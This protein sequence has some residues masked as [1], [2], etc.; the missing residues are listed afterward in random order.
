MKKYSR[1]V[2][3]VFL[4]IVWLISSPNVLAEDYTFGRAWQHVQ[5]VSDAIASEQANVERSELLQ[6]A[7]KSLNYPQVELSGSYTRLD[8]EVKADALD[9]NPLSGLQDNPIGQDI[10][11]ALGGQTAFTTDITNQSFGRLALTALWP[12]YTGGR[13]TAAQDI[14]K[15]Q[16]EIATQLFDIQRHTVFEELVKIYFGVVLSQQNLETHKQAELGFQQHLENAKKLESQGQI[17]KVERLS[18]AV[19]HDRARI[20]TLKAQKALEIA[21]VSLRQLLHASVDVYPTDQL[22]T[23][24]SIPED[25]IFISSSLDSS[26]LLKSLEARDR[27]LQAI[28]KSNRGRYHPEVSLYADYALYNDDSIVSDLLP[29]WSVGIG[30]TVPLV[31]RFNR[32]KNIGATLKAQE[33]VARLSD[34]TRRALTV[35]TQVAYKKAQ[36]ALQEFEGR[37]S[38]LELSKENLFMRQKAFSEGLSTS[39]QLIDSEVFVSVARTE[40]SA[41]AYQYI[42]SLSQLLTLSGEVGSFGQYQN[43]ARQEKSFKESFR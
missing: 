38:T 13:I 30:F 15:A 36:Q 17:A 42:L 23:N 9:F 6:D 18:I 2:Y 12:I 7:T 5:Q 28:E 39:S 32:S 40:R 24:S 4:I 10:I 14:S 33:S 21:L 3:S 20:A 1:R 29:E 19:A 34:S 35:A 43:M 25:Q 41:A 16:T 27:E 8:D 31:D 26:P 37:G 11:D 22:F